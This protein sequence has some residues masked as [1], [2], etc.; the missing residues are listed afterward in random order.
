V[1]RLARSRLREGGR[2]TV[3]DTTALV[4]E[5]SRRFLDAGTLR[6]DDRRSFFAYASRVMRSVIIDSI[7]QR[8]AERHG[9]DAVQGPPDTQIAERPPGAHAR[10]VERRRAGADAILRVHEALLAL[11]QAEP[12]LAR[13]V[14][15][16]YFGGYTEAEIAAALKM[17]D[18]TVRGG[19]AR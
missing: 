12:R 7:R 16:H 2:S 14:E 18:P 17:T 15:M 3:L 8:R 19:G 4:H 1:R 11:E 10:S 13:V 5:S 6:S 9:G